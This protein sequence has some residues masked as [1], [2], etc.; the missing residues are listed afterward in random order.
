MKKSHITRQQTL[1]AFFPKP[2]LFQRLRGSDVT[3]YDPTKHK[4]EAAANSRLIR[5]KRHY[6]HT[7]S[8]QG[9]LF[10][11]LNEF[12]EFIAINLFDR[13]D[14]FSNSIIPSGERIAEASVDDD[15]VFSGQD[16]NSRYRLT[17]EGMHLI[18]YCLEQKI[19]DN[20]DFIS[21]DTPVPSSPCAKRR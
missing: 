17:A 4:T 8:H 18:R 19:L 16:Y 11:A 9:V 5:K 21:S 2:H 12:R 20:E 13:V 3:I 1:G 14:E 10:V 6:I 15:H 7:R